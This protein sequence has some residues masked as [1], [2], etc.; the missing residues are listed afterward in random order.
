MGGVEGAA[1]CSPEAAS[2]LFLRLFPDSSVLLRWSSSHTALSSKYRTRL[3][4][5]A[6]SRT[7]DT[8]YT[9]R[10]MVSSVAPLNCPATFP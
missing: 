7:A 10:H 6:V 1:V 3:I 5:T 4:S 8:T 9:V 2:K